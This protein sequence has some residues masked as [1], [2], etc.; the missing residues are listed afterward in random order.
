MK[1][2]ADIS[3]INFTKSGVGEYTKNLLLAL[4]N[5]DTKNQYIFFNNQGLKRKS[6][7]EN[8]FLD[9]K[10]VSIKNFKLPQ[11]FLYYSWEKL[12]QPRINYFLGKT[13]IFHSHNFL[14][15][16]VEA[17]KKIITIYDLSFIHF[18][19]YFTKEFHK[20]YTASIGNSIKEADLI[21]T[22]SHS[23]KQDIIDIYD[24]KEEKV[25]VIYGAAN[26]KFK[27]IKQ[28]VNYNDKIKNI[29]NKFKIR[30]N[31][32]LFV[33]T[34]QPRKNLLRLIKAYSLLPKS[35]LN[36]YQLVVVG[37]KGWLFK[38]IF[39]YVQEKNLNQNIVFLDEVN[40]NEMVCLYNGANIFILPSFYEGFGLPILEAFACG[41]PVITSN[42]SSLKEIGKD[43]ALL[44][45][46]Y[47]VKKINS[48]ITSLIENE[49]IKKDLIFKG[50]NKVNNFSWEK[51]AQKLLKIYEEIYQ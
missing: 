32:F 7:E 41:T 26:N 23:A 21:I 49:S 48:A 24:V 11:K 39:K 46:P 50:K 51:S 2:A 15:P 19:Q 31:Y 13:D 18:P 45:N 1:I 28:E 29:K 10:K 37:N 3:V 36:N 27:D 47:S 34:I 22:I 30:N 8:I 9:N 25:K 20:I 12:K 4:L 5:I 14:L 17:K 44:V 16:P 38:N 6:K 35:L 33:G 40:E 42:C 43:C